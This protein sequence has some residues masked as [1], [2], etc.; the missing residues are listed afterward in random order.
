MY[1]EHRDVAA[2]GVDRQEHRAVLSQRER[3][4][5]SQGI[6]RSSTA[7]TASRETAS[8]FERTVGIPSVSDDLV[9]VGGIRHGEH[10]TRVFAFLCVTADW[11]SCG[12]SQHNNEQQTNCLHNRI[13]PFFVSIL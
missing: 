2:P 12:D 10:R 4:L 3:G 9:S 8:F 1:A 6:R 7:S 13:T 5:R 11:Q